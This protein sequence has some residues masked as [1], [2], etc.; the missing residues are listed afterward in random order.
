MIRYVIIFLMLSSCSKEVTIDIPAPEP[1]PVLNCLFTSDSLFKVHLSESTSVFD[2][3]FAYGAGQKIFLYENNIIKDSLRWEDEY[4]T[5]N[6]TPQFNASYRIEWVHKDNISSVDDIPEFVAMQSASFHDSVAI[7]SDGV[8]FSECEIEFTDNSFQKNYYEISL[9]KLYELN[10]EIATDEAY[11]FSSDPVIEAEGLTDYYP[12]SIIL[13]DTL[14]NG[15]NYKLKI[16]YYPPYWS[17]GEVVDNKYKVIIHFRSISENYYKYKK[18]LIVHEYNQ[19]GDI[20]DGL[21][22]PVPMFTNIEGGYGI[23]AGY[24]VDI[25]TISK[26]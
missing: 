1:K 26:K 22:N 11:L 23:F 6:I 12:S 9:F 8:F 16:N 18:A 10:N 21:G 5:S 13:S 7:D 19:D 3:P 25:D 15:Q 2:P 14:I 20:W 4:Y 24:I 17:T